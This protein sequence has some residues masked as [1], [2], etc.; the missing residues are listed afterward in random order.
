M[1]GQD[2]W[3]L[4]RIGDG[5]TLVHFGDGTEIPAERVAAFEALGRGAIP[6]GQYGG[7]T[8]ML[9]D[10]GR[11]IPHPDKD[12][13]NTLEP[14]GPEQPPEPQRPEEPATQKLTGGGDK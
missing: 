4:Q 8:V 7:G 3:L 14:P 11:W 9:W 12:P 1:S 10:R 6:K 13:R 2:G 5:F